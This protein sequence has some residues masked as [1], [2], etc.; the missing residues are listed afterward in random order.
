MRLQIYVSTWFELYF[1]R[2]K[3][4][5]HN[6]ELHINILIIYKLTKKKGIKKRKKKKKD[7]TTE[8]D[9]F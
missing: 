3:L 8:I 2:N 5:L 6:I 9:K 7:K 4:N 1:S